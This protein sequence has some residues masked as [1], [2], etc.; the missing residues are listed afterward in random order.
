MWVEID[1]FID[2][3]EIVVVAYWCVDDTDFVSLEEAGVSAVIFEEFDHFI[4]LV[5]S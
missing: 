5:I 2:L 3:G 4:S 1:I